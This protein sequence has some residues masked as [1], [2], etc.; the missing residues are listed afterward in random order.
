[1]NRKKGAEYRVQAV[2]ERNG[3]KYI[4]KVGYQLAMDLIKKR[5]SKEAP[6]ICSICQTRDEYGLIYEVDI[7]TGIN[8][9]VLS[10]CRRCRN[11]MKTNKVAFIYSAFDTNKRRY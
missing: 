6:I 5:R 7:P 9:H 1:M 3:K 2:S 11:K 8:K 4:I 10:I